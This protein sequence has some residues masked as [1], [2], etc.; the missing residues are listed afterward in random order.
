VRVL[1][2]L[3]HRLRLGFPIPPASPERKKQGKLYFFFSLMNTRSVV[4]EKTHSVCFMKRQ[5]KEK[6]CFL[7]LLFLDEKKG[8]TK[9][10]NGKNLFS[11][12]SGYKE[13]K[14]I[15]LHNLLKISCTR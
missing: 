2:T 9:K 5:R 4:Y 7:I 11:S 6:G 15:R 10:E 3:L 13:A 8:K 1:V 14:I 12:L